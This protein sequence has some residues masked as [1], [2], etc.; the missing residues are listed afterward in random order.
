MP[1]GIPKNGKR[2]IT[3]KSNTTK[4]KWTA[5][6]E[7]ISME[8]AVPTV[9]L[10]RGADGGYR[11]GVRAYGLTTAQAREEC[12]REFEQLE[13]VVTAIKART[14]VNLK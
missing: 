5:R 10:E 11:Y 12:A 13:N 8:P 9:H 4:R 3:R 14:G 2:R 7:N 6:V 1:R